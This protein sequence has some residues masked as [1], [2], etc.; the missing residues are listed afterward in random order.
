[1]KVIKLSLLLAIFCA[2]INAQGGG[3][4]R[5]VNFRNFT[6]P[7]ENKD[8]QDIPKFIKVQRGKY[9]EP[10]ESLINYM[11]LRVK[12]IIYG[13]LTGDGQEEAAVL[14]LYGSTTANFSLTDTYVFTMKGKRPKLLGI[15]K[16]SRVEHDY[17]SCCADADP[18]NEEV[19]GGR[20]ISRGVLTVEHFVGGSHSSPTKVISMS[21]KWNGKDF[22]LA[23]RPFKRPVKKSDKI[24]RIE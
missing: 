17:D 1:M 3:S 4:I 6:Y 13:D 15:L 8:F 24:I 10:H 19:A 9:D 14:V 11:Y 21:Y 16:E 22:V 2:P 18:W 5:R 12:D 23:S 20:K 7:F